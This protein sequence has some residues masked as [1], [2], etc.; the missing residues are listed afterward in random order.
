MK[1][2]RIKKRKKLIAL[3]STIVVLAAGGIGTGVAFAAMA[4][5]KKSSPQTPSVSPSSSAANSDFKELYFRAEGENGQKVKE[6]KLLL[7]SPS[8]NSSNAS[9]L[10]P[11]PSSFSVP[12]GSTV[13]YSKK[14]DLIDL[15]HTENGVFS[16]EAKPGKYDLTVQGGESESGKTLSWGSYFLSPTFEVNLS[17]NSETLTSVSDPC[18]F[19]NA[20]EKEVIVGA[21]NP[22]S[23]RIEGGKAS[24][25]P[26][27][28]LPGSSHPYTYQ[29][30]SFL[31]FAQAGKNA[32]GKA[33]SLTPLVFSLSLSSQTLVKGSIKVNGIPLSS[34]KGAS[35]SPSSSSIAFSPLA[36]ETIEEKG[37]SPLPF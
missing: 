18:G 31:P 7:T 3:L 13:S 25:A 6:V 17:S 16:F 35:L 5:V 8:T 20:K 4:A 30:E 21:P 36:L 15:T 34:L 32:K 12:K 19:V 9:S 11:S 22:S 27:A 1:K 29:V 28:S 10:S 24:S 2:R 23:E 14:G 37:K 33:A 26:F